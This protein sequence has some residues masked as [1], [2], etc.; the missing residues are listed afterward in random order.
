VTRRS[1][2]WHDAFQL[3]LTYRPRL[4]DDVFLKPYGQAV[5]FFGLI[6][7][8]PGGRTITYDGWCDFV[9]R[10]PDFVRGKPVQGKNPVTGEPITIFPRPDGASVIKDGKEIANVGWSLSGPD[11][12]I[13]SG[14]RSVV[15]S[16]GREIA[17]QLDAELFELL[18]DDSTRSL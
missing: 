5:E 16:L 10:R 8:R 3:L 12:V 4:S 6:R 2:K 17:M 11:E 18:P 13:L 15:I 7:M 9:C 1:R 14:E